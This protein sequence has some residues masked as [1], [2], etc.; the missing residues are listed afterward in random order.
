MGV[1]DGWGWSMGFFYCRSL[2]FD[3]GIAYRNT[4]TALLIV[5]TVLRSSFLAI[6]HPILD[7]AAISATPSGLGNPV[8]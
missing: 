5:Y 8:E 3:R 6:G 1:V 4:S 7:I 2:L